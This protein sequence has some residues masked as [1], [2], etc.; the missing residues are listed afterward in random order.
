M[1]KKS[2]FAENLAVRV[3]AGSSIRDAAVAVGCAESTA[4]NVSSTIDF[5]RR[6]GELRAAMTDAAVGELAAGAAE[7]VATLRQLL[8]KA[9]DPPQRIAAA[10]AILAALG[11]VT[12]LS[13][14]RRRLDEIEKTTTPSLKVAQ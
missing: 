14:I 12:E 1:T 5:R 11:P 2:K 3:A 8:D 6:V 9:N 4:Y 10:K 7:A 13:E